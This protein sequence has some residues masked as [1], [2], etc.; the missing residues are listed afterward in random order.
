M[1]S[2]RIKRTPIDSDKSPTVNPLLQ[3]YAAVSVEQPCIFALFWLIWTTAPLQA[4]G[5]ET[6]SLIAIEQV[7]ERARKEGM[8]VIVVDPMQLGTTKPPETSTA[9]MERLKSDAFA[10]RQKL[11]DIV[12]KLPAFPGH[13]KQAILRL[14]PE[15]HLHWPL[16]TAGFAILFLLI[17]WLPRYL[18]YI[19]AGGAL[20]AQFR[21]TPQHDSERIGYL[22][23]RGTSRM[24]GLTVQLV[25]AVLLIL[26]FDMGRDHLRYTA[27]MVV[28]YWALISSYSIFMRN[29]LAIDATQYRTLNI[30]DDAGDEFL[31]GFYLLVRRRYIYAASCVCDAGHRRRRAYTGAGGLGHCSLPSA[32]NRHGCPPSA[33]RWTDAV[34]IAG[35]RLLGHFGSD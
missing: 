31:P 25:G 27:L 34:C 9:M 20:L 5:P 2:F 16:V 35:Q 18:L 32:L 33:Y 1:R 10:A 22:F 21:E 29:L 3:S 13:L 11:F 28:A 12:E 14:S 23:A 19:W 24:I 7:I 26:A 6:T 30:G 15:K 17:A 4:K 8:R